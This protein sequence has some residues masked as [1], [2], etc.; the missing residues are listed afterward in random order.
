MSYGKLRRNISKINSTSR[1]F[2]NAS[3][4]GYRF[5]NRKTKSFNN[6]LVIL[7]RIEKLNLLIFQA[8][9]SLTEVSKI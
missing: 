8:S 3:A 9:F 6:I 2:H 7:F 4:S 5:Y 1:D